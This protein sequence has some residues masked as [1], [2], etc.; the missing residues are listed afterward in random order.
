MWSTS[1]RCI[2]P[3]AVV[4]GDK[5]WKLDRLLTHWPLRAGRWKMFTRTPRVFCARTPRTTTARSPSS[6][7]YTATESGWVVWTQYEIILIINN[8]DS[9]VT[10]NLRWL[11]CVSILLEP[12]MIFS[13]VRSTN[14]KEKVWT[15]SHQ[16]KPMFIF[17]EA[18][19]GTS[20]KKKT[21][22]CGN[23]E[24]TGGGVYPNPTSI[25]YCF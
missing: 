8:T 22:K 13:I 7:P 25:F 6:N 9:G 18:N 20:S 15:N 4:Q 14:K 3:R 12:K 10:K 5:Y 1:C 24:K 2:C 21:G 23:F 17:K 16:P 11:Q 19:K